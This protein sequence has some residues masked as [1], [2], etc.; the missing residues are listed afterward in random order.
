MENFPTSQSILTLYEVQS[1]FQNRWFIWVR[2][3]RIRWATNG[4]FWFTMPLR[5]CKALTRH[6]FCHIISWSICRHSSLLQLM[7]KLI[8]NL[9]EEVTINSSSKIGVK[10]KWWKIPHVVRDPLGI[11]LLMGVHPMFRSQSSKWTPC[12][13]QK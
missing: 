6:L 11:S 10:V 12:E 4:N 7:W 1:E 5:P 13:N 3:K 8:S 2:R 9:L